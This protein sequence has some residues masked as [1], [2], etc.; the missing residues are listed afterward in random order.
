MRSENESKPT[1]SRIQAARRADIISAAITVINRDGYVT[2]SLENVA[3]HIGASKGTV[4]YHFKSKRSLEKA[5]VD[6]VYASGAA[7]MTPPVMA[8]GNH[9]E[10][11]TAYISSNLRFIAE[12]KEQ[13]AAVQ[14]IAKN[15]PLTDQA[16]LAIR[17]LEQMLKEG[18]ESGELAGFDPH[19]LA[20]AIR[21]VIDGSAFYILDNPSLDIQVY[22]QGIVQLFEKATQ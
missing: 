16:D 14:S 10:R 22:I 13:V 19:T 2:A 5:I 18:Q 12:H 3:K 7:Y 9:H 4:L 6:T 11:V 17:T 15:T 8:A 1:L 21:L 20:I